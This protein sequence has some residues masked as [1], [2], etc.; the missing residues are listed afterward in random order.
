MLFESSIVN[1]SFQI[2][3]LLYWHS[4]HLLTCVKT[5]HSLI[6]LFILG[7]NSEVYFFSHFFLFTRLR[8]GTNMP[9]AL[10]FCFWPRPLFWKHV[11]TTSLFY[12]PMSLLIFFITVCWTPFHSSIFLIVLPL[13]SQFSKQIDFLILIL[14]LFMYSSK[15]HRTPNFMLLHSLTYK[16]CC[17]TSAWTHAAAIPLE[18]LCYLSSFQIFSST[19]RLLK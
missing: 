17:N 12:S 13:G 1:L 5:S 19:A 9:F 4:F 18:F 8:G 6:T 14:F 3:D 7:V 16:D 11:L 10:H 2:F 15:S